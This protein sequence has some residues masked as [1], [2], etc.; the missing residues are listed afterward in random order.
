MELKQP[1]RGPGV[2]SKQIS[3]KEE[4]TDNLKKLGE[5]YEKGKDL[6]TVL[7]PVPPSQEQ[8]QAYHALRGILQEMVSLAAVQMQ[9]KHWINEN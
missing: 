2:M 6:T 1:A 4:F 3:N 8:W 7:L 5:L 9:H